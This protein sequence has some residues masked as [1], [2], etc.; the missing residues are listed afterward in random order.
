MVKKK[1]FNTIDE[2]IQ[3]FPEDI[4]KQLQE[5]RSAVKNSAPV[6]EEKISYQ[7]P[8]FFQKGILVYFAANKKHIGFYPTLSP[9]KAFEKELKIYKTTKGSIH[10]PL[11][12][13][14]PID[15]IK[16]IVKFRVNENLEKAQNKKKKY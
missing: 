7:M 16:R 12:K 6:A 1:V 8:A 15:L 4:Q 11:D 2:Y 14:L 5:L 9:M 13:P 3:S 10:F